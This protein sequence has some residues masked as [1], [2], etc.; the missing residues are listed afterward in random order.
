MKTQTFTTYAAAAHYKE[1]NLTQS[2]RIGAR[3]LQISASSK[4]PSKFVLQYE[5]YKAA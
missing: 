2:Q 4:S 5:A 1:W 3:I